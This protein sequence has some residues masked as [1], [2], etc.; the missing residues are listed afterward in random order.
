[1]RGLWV[2]AL[3]SLALLLAIGFYT[4]SE[5]AKATKKYTA[6]ASE[7]EAMI[8]DGRWQAARAALE[9]ATE[10]F[11][12]CG[13]VLQTWVNHAD[14]DVVSLALRELKRALKEEERFFA[15]MTLEEFKEGVSHLY[16]RDA[17]ALKNIL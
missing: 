1:M 7:L 5:S 16:H 14:V 4:A 8:E 13:D 10:T 11:E 6:F 17:F 12:A 15:L 3:V 2:K 9:E